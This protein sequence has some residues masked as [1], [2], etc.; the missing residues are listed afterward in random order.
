MKVYVHIQMIVSVTEHIISQR[1]LREC[2][3]Q[4]TGDSPGKAFEREFLSLDRHVLGQS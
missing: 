3:L 1:F 2:V 4:N